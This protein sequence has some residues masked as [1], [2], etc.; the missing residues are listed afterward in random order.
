MVNG[1]QKTIGEGKGRRRRGSEGRGV[2][3]VAGE[4][5]KRKR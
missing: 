3:N 5:L 1:G 2:K 4:R